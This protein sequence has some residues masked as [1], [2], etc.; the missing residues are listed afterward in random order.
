LIHKTFGT[1]LIEPVHPVTQ[2]LA[3]HATD[4]RSI[5]PAHTVQNR[6]NR[7]QPTALAHIL[8]RSRQPAK[9]TGRIVTP[10]LHR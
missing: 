7:Q 3:V 6:R 8:R 10:Q 9:L 5:G 1:S 4:P 2:R